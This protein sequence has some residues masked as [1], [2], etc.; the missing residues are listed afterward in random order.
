MAMQA[1]RFGP[2]RVHENIWKFVAPSLTIH[3]L[4]P[5]PSGREASWICRIHKKRRRCY[6]HR[7]R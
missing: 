1:G 3:G 7:R 6:K 2:W 4:P 5:N